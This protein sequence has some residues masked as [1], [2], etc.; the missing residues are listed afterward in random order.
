MR[1]RLRSQRAFGTAED[2]DLSGVLDPFRHLHQYS[3]SE[4]IKK[5]V[6]SLKARSIVV[7]TTRQPACPHLPPR[8]VY[9]CCQGGVNSC[10]SQ[11]GIG[12]S[13]SK[14]RTWLWY[15]ACGMYCVLL[16]PLVP[17][18]EVP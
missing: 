14:F 13:Q 17:V 10:G 1:K 11:A 3:F 9:V 8:R 12:K 2:A 5:K 16:Q 7:E 18:G 4:K 6:E 15:P